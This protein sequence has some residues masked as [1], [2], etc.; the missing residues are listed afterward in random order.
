MLSESLSV[1]YIQIYFFT[2]SDGDININ[3]KYK[4]NS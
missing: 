4:M 1:N 3:V 2:E